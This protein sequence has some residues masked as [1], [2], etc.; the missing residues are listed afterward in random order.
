MTLGGAPA[1]A[2]A[3]RP[4]AGPPAPVSAEAFKDLAWRSIGPANMGGRVSA[5]AV[6]EKRSATFYVGFG[7]GGVFKTTNLGTTWSAVFEK[8]KVASIGAIAVWQKNPDVVWVGTGEANSR[9]SSS[10]GNGIYRS[11]DGGATWKHLGLEKTQTI[12]RVVPD[13]A[14]INTVFVAALGRLWG[15]NPERGV[16]VTR[17]GGATWSLALKADT[18]TGACDLVMDPADPRVLYAAMYARRR[19][20]WSYSS[21]GTSGG[22]FKTV[23]GGRTWRKLGEGLPAETGRIGLDLYRKDPHVL[24][25]VVESAEGG[26]TTTFDSRSR[27]GGVFRSDD[28]GEHWTRVGPWA[29]RPFYFSQIRVQPDDSTRLYLLGVDLWLSDDGGRT[30]RPGGGKNLHPDFHALWIDPGNGDRVLAGTDGGVFMS[31]DRAATW[32]FL[33]NL[34]VGEFYNLAVDMRDPYFIY[35]GLQDNQSWGGPSRTRFTAPIRG[36][37]SRATTA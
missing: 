12:A 24:F 32:D 30:F 21:G 15:D 20:P 1:R 16:Y 37:T 34:A 5:F 9:N 13:P 17:D 4:A 7:T 19:T 6:V 23:D 31:H 11:G 14:D 35:G 10:W 18:K 28:R 26:R 8:E 29:P 27:A 36:S 33:N 22:I 2:A 25:A 3:A